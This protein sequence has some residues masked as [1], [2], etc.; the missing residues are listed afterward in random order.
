MILDSG[1]KNSRFQS[2]DSFMVS[3]L[4]EVEREKTPIHILCCSYSQ[5]PIKGH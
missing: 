2:S 1:K 3:N 4:C 5:T